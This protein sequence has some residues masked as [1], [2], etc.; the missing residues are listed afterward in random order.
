MEEKTYKLLNH[1]EP[2]PYEEIKRTYRGY[3]VFITNV[4]FDAEDRLCRGI[5]AVIGRT[6][7][8]GVEDGIYKQFD[9][10]EYAPCRDRNFLRRGLQ[11]LLESMGVEQS[12]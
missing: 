2:M 10:E 12:E 3:W 8:D 11:I 9:T 1:T 7:F 6:P 4:Q 5:P